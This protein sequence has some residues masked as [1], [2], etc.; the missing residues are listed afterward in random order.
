MKLKEWNWEN[1]QFEEVEQPDHVIKAFMEFVLLNKQWPEQLEIMYLRFLKLR[2]D[3]TDH[4]NDLALEAAKDDTLRCAGITVAGEPCE[5]DATHG[6]FCDEH[7][8]ALIQ[9]AIDADTQVMS[10]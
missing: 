7:E 8:T 5:L 3:L 4:R 6:S 10:A 2:R 9:A 1:E